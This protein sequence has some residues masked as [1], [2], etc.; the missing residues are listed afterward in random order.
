MAVVSAGS[1]V[2][3]RPTTRSALMELAGRQILASRRATTLAWVAFFGLIG[4]GFG[5]VVLA[6]FV[7]DQWHG[8]TLGLS[9]VA[10]FAI[11]VPLAMLFRLLPLPHIPPP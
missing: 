11:V 2:L 8:F 7:P 10:T 5:F 9:E 1:I 3:I 6:Q 4:L